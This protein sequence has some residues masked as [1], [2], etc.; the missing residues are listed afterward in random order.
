MPY[1]KG[2][3]LFNLFS[4]LPLRGIAVAIAFAPGTDTLTAFRFLL[5]ALDMADS[6]GSRVS[7][8]TQTIFR[9]QYRTYL[10]VTHP[11]LD[12]GL[13]TLRCIVDKLIEG[14]WAWHRIEQEDHVG[15]D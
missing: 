13:P 1:L 3:V 12:F 11:F 15:S 2:S 5:I 7:G 10:Q 8:K 4:E 14:Q 9:S 6:E